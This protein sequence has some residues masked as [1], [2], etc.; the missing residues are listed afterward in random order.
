MI[1]NLA[2][3]K[4]FWLILLSYFLLTLPGIVRTPFATRGETR[5]ALA[6]A[7]ML[8]T[9]NYLLPEVYDRGV[10]SK[11]P[12][13]HWLMATTSK[14]RRILL[15]DEISARAPTFLISLLFLVAFYLILSN[16]A[17]KQLALI[18]SLTLLIMPEWIRSS[19]VARVDGVFAPLLALSLILYLIASKN[20]L[21]IISG[22]LLGLA[23]LAKG[24]VTIVIFTLTVA[25]WNLF[26]FR[27][28][29]FKKSFS[30]LARTIPYCLLVSLIWYV[31]AISIDG[32]DFE[33]KFFEENFGR[34]F[35]SK[36]G[37]NHSGFYLLATFFLGS[38]PLS[39]TMPFAIWELG[40]QKIT[41]TTINKFSAI[42]IIII[43]LFFLIPASKR[44]T[45]LLPTYPFFAILLADWLEKSRLAIKVFSVT[46]KTFSV[47]FIIV[48]SISFLIS[49]NAPAIELS[50]I[51]ENDWSNLIRF[52]LLNFERFDLL[53]ALATLIMASYVLLGEA[54]L[55]KFLGF[56]IFIFSLGFA[57]LMPKY[58]QLV[59]HQPFAE[60]AR[61]ISID[62]ARLKSYKHSFYGVSL[63]L[64]K[65]FSSVDAIEPENGD[66]IFLFEDQTANLKKQW[67]DFCEF[68]LI[69]RSDGWFEKPFKKA[70]VVKCLRKNE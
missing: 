61:G 65:P 43:N 47:I 17:S 63:I 26:E 46:T 38:L 12:L 15:V 14:V 40:G 34:F 42:V 44:G 53:L 55:L 25:V 16:V 62:R 3:S 4:A 23:V 70:I 49:Y 39:I 64:G 7:N 60:V 57:V 9:G 41:S 31:L 45:Y 27:Q 10:P 66:L 20:W 24:P 21:L 36:G 35:A 59:A 18:T 1:T 50:R 33:N 22:G 28:V 52:I 19:Q 29:W 37:H 8:K 51:A 6:A 30:D 54:N 58:Y 5:E 69:L 11:P 2:R 48:A 67:G 13:T 68:P 56:W 32:F